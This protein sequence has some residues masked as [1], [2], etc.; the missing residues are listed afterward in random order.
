[1]AGVYGAIFYFWKARGDDN[2]D[3]ELDSGVAPGLEEM[4]ME[5]TRGYRSQGIRRKKRSVVG[6]LLA[7]NGA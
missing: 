3:E 6:S 4:G 2:G 5:E 7:V 1:L